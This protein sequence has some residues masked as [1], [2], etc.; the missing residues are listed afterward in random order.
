MLMLT[1]YEI[2]YLYVVKYFLNFLQILR[3]KY[4]NY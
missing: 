2:E 4:E 3:T 1:M